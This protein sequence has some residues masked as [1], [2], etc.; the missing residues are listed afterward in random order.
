MLMSVSGWSGPSF[1]FVSSSDCSRSGTARPAARRPGSPSQVVHTARACRGGRGRARPS[2]VARPSSQTSPRPGVSPSAA[3]RLAERSCIAA[4]ASGSPMAFP[5]QLLHRLVEPLARALL[6][7]AC[8][9]AIFSAASDPAT[10][11]PQDLVPFSLAARLGLLA[12]P[13]CRRARLESS[14]TSCRDPGHQSEQHQARR[15]HL[16]LFRLTN[17]LSR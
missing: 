7:A 10:I 6:A 15:D 9:S 14:R 3:E 8:R 17:F 2:V 5:L 1:A 12:R 11:E 4:T 13:A 16:P